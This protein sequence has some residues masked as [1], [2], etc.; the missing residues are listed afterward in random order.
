M[1]DTVMK[2]VPGLKIGARGMSGNASVLKALCER[3]GDARVVD[4]MA[5][6]RVA[7]ARETKTAKVAVD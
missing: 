1:N 4:V 2:P 7:Q 5:F 6:E 3:Y